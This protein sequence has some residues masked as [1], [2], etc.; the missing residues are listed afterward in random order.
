MSRIGAAIRLLR[1]RVEKLEERIDPWKD[2][3]E[4]LHGDGEKMEPV[5]PPIVFIKE[6]T[7]EEVPAKDT[8]IQR[9]VYEVERE[10]DAAN[11]SI[12]V[13][14]QH[15]A[16]LRS[17]IGELQMTN[18]ALTDRVAG[19]DKK[20][21]AMY[22][23]H[24]K[25]RSAN[26]GETVWGQRMI[27]DRKEAQRKLEAVRMDLRYQQRLNDTSLNRIRQLSDLKKTKKKVL[28][29]TGAKHRF[30][31]YANLVGEVVPYFGKDDVGKRFKSSPS[32]YV[33]YEDAYILEV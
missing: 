1:K 9:A 6:G 22:T 31:W 33:L 28:Y 10:L 18:H 17:E 14:I 26:P 20:I 27:A 3:V 25:L 16:N 15:T 8:R 32:K 11:N 4:H 24:E 12:Q 21:S 19:R 30:F 5:P 29:I 2:E 13:Y 7:T 23:A